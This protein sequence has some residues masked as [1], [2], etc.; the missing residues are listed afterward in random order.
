[1]RIENNAQTLDQE[2]IRLTDSVGKMTAVQQGLDKELEKLYSSGFKDRKF[3]ELKAKVKESESVIIEMNKIIQ[4][5]INSLKQRSQLIK[6]Y[7]N[8]RI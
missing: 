5:M 4:E 6:K 2:I 8:V 1:M 7:H 3:E